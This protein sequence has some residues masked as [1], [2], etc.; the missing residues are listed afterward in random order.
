MESIKKLATVSGLLL[1]LVGQLI[2]FII[3]FKKDFSTAI[4]ASLAITFLITVVA[5]IT[6]I[7]SK[8][9][10]RLGDPSQTTPR[11]PRPA[12]RSAGM[13]LFC[14]PILLASSFLG[15]RAYHHGPKAGFLILVADFDGPDPK[16]FRVSEIIV[17][18]IRLATRPYGDI[19]VRTLERTITAQQSSSEAIKIARENGAAIVLW[20]WYGSTADTAV[21]TVHFEIIDPLEMSRLP[22]SQMMTPP[23][24]EL[25][26]FALQMR[27]A[28]GYT[29]V[30]LI[31]AGLARYEQ[32]DYSGAVDRLNA[33]EQLVNEEPSLL[34]PTYLYFHRGTSYIQL[35]KQDL[36]IKDLN[37]CIARKPKFADAFINRA[38]ALYDQ[39]KYAEAKDDADAAIQLNPSEAVAYNTR[40]V[41]VEKIGDRASARHAALADFNKA[42]ELNPGLSW[43]YNNR[44]WIYEQQDDLDHAIEDYNRA[45][46]YGS[47]IALENRAM[48]QY[49]AGEY[50]KALS[51]YDALLNRE[52]KNPIFYAHRGLVHAALGEAAAATEDCNHAISISPN[53]AH[54]HDIRGVAHAQLRDFDNAGRDFATAIT[55]DPK[56]ARSYFDRGT[57]YMQ[58]QNY[59]S[60][61]KDFTSAIKLDPEFGEAYVSRGQAYQKIGKAHLASQDFAKATHHGSRFIV[62]SIEVLDDAEKRPNGANK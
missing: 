36:A 35:N 18:K 7:T 53:D 22:S 31:A 43:A 34:D 59:D 5:L 24:S 51:D 15:W 26:N 50:E 61:I 28:D 3:A 39:G 47:A 20:G 14:L 11:Y 44:G 16:S 48:A 52:P 42:L 30:S 40:G 27:I 54:L 2:S 57:M 23:L 32:R 21:A 19:E 9:P 56:F 45:I 8:V 1:G 55:L 10:S 4:A 62:Q 6:I 37:L 46:V 49:Y 38:V 13:A 25:N 12:R 17:E 29:Y 58:L 60:A 41:I 33:A